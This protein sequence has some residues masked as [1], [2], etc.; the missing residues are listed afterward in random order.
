MISRLTACAATFAVLAASTIAWAATAE[1]NRRAELR[2]APVVQLP[3]VVVI[4]KR[5]AVVALA[6]SQAVQR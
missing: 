5:S 3:T 1:I 4:S 6:P 2:E